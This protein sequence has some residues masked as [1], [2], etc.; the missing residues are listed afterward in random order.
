M[1]FLFFL[2]CFSLTWFLFPDNTVNEKNQKLYLSTHENP[3][4]LLLL[5]ECR[6]FFSQFLTN[7]PVARA[8]YCALFPE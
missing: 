2:V 5:N 1:I 4:R 6:F 3:T 8:H 7:V